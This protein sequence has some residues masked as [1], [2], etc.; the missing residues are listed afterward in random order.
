MKKVIVD[1]D[2]CIGCFRCRTACNSVFDI[3]DDEKAKV[4]DNLSKQDIIAAE[5]AIAACPTKAIR[6]EGKYS[7]FDIFRKIRKK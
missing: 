1:K 3:G 7:I 2:K 6:I 4:K 5:K